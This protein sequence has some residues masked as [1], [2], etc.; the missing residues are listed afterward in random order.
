MQALSDKG[1]ETQEKG[2]TDNLQIKVK[3]I[4]TLATNIK[5]SLLKRVNSQPC[6]SQQVWPKSLCVVQKTFHPFKNLHFSSRVPRFRMPWVTVHPHISS[7]PQ[8]LTGSNALLWDRACTVCTIKR[9]GWSSVAVFISWLWSYCNTTLTLPGMAESMQPRAVLI[10]TSY[11]SLI[12]PVSLSS[13][14][15]PAYE[16]HGFL[17]PSWNLSRVLHFLI[18]A[19][20]YTMN[21]KDNE[22]QK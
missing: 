12:P 9:A 6:W 10:W 20:D 8:L 2:K 1:D 5:A 3:S 15:R 19:E 7:A 13:A 16:S 21:S 22:I 17:S 11:N 4:I 14:K 18:K